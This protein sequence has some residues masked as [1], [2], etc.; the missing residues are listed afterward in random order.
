LLRN[1]A[2]ALDC[3]AGVLWVPRGDQ[4]APRTFW[5]SRATD[6]SEFEAEIGGRRIGRGVA[7]PGAVWDTKEPRARSRAQDGGTTTNTTE[8]LVAIPARHGDEVLAVLEFFSASLRTALSERLIRSLAGIGFELGEFL[9]HRRGELS[10][11]RLTPRELEVLVLA[12]HGRT[13]REIA[14]ELFVSPSTVATHF[15]HIYE[16][17]GA[18]DRASAVAKALR[19]G[20]IE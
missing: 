16:K 12:S 2:R 7:L 15:K 1:L 8:G 5:H 11:R 18:S 17:Y 20:L 13:A 9:S 19:E 3:A 14:D 10:P 4:L 6:S